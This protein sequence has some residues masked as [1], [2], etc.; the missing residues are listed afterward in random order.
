MTS[1]NDTYELN[2]ILETLTSL[3]SK[4]LERAQERLYELGVETPTVVRRPGIP[5]PVTRLSIVAPCQISS[6]PLRIE[7]EWN[8]NCLLDYL[9][10]QGGESLSEE[11]IAFIYQDTTSN[12][13]KTI[14]DGMVA[15]RQ[16][17]S[18]TT[19][20][21][22]DAPRKAP[23]KV[24]ANIGEDADFEISHLTL[25]PPFLGRT[26]DVLE[27]LVPAALVHKHPA[28]RLVGVLDSI[29]SEL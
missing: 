17:L 21:D 6:C 23:S 15:I 14:E 11:E 25:A 5:C 26:N 10:S 24:E 13:R 16:N 2:S 28:I 12:V 8:R 4:G 22:F 18:K 27:K 1:D 20:T 9:E 19:G 7:N 29:I 3:D